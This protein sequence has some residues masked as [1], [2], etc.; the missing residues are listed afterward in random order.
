MARPTIELHPGYRED[1]Q[2]RQT[3]NGEHDADDSIGSMLTEIS[4]H[5]ALLGSGQVR[6]LR[7]AAHR[8]TV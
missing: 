4:I 6:A 1:Q 3:I 8:D 2:P 7:T 5:V